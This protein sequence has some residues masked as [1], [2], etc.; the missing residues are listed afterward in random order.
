MPVWPVERLLQQAPFEVAQLALG[1][2]AL[3]VAV[4]DGGDAGRI[5]AAIL[6]PA[7]RVDEVGQRPALYPIM[8]TMPHMRFVSL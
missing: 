4:L 5:V 3:E 7:Q 8:P 2:A 1:A 6:E